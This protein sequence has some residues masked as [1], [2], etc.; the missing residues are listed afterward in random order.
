[1]CISKIMIFMIAVVFMFSVPGITLAAN[2]VLNN[3]KSDHKI[4][5]N[6]YKPDIF[7]F[8]TV[9]Y[10][11]NNGVGDITYNYMSPI[12]GIGFTKVIIYNRQKQKI[13]FNDRRPTIF[14]SDNTAKIEV[15]DQFLNGISSAIASKQDGH[16]FVLDVTHNSFEYSNDEMHLSCVPITYR[17]R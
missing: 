11:S 17:L 10:P 3:Y 13:V 1:M 2:K 16:H 14:E 12:F 5:V 6:I 15:D 8:H 9:E 4:T 7:S